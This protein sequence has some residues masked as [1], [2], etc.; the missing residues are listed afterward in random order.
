M[1]G[2]NE[3]IEG[4]PINE[5]ALYVSNH[6]GMLDFFI[7]LKYLN[8]Y[9]LSKAE[10]EDIP[11]VGFVAQFTGIF[12]LE[13]NSKDSRIAARNAIM[14]ILNSGYN[15]LLYP[16]G[17]TNDAKT[18]KSFRVGAFEVAASNGFK[19]VPIALEFSSIDDLWKDTPI[20]KQFIKQLGKP[21]TRVKM[22]FGPALH[23][24]DATYL[25]N[26]S[27]KWIDQKLEA[28]Q[29]GWSKVH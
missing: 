6:R 26:E 19:V 25:M 16:E 21:H 3:Q 15:V 22:A 12:Y 8:A 17:T 1:F 24:E 27:K 10:V 11:V 28:M 29:T 4:V 23:S 9:I 13:R 18:T 7:N 20:M 2:T 5:P 14:K